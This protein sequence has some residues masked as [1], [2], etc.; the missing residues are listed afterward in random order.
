MATLL[1]NAGTA[2]VGDSFDFGNWMADLPRLPPGGYTRDWRTTENL[3]RE[4]ANEASRVATQLCRDDRAH[5][6][7]VGAKILALYEYTDPERDGW[8]YNK[9]IK[10]SKLPQFIH[11]EFAAVRQE[12]L[13]QRREEKG[14]KK[15]APLSIAGRRRFTRAS[16]TSH[17]N[18]PIPI[19]FINT[20]RAGI[21]IPLTWYSNYHLE[22][23]RDLTRL[24]TKAASILDS[25]GITKKVTILDIDR[26]LRNGWPT[27]NSSDDLTLSTYDICE[28]N[29]LRAWEQVIPAHDVTN[30][31]SNTTA[32]LVKHS[33]FF[34]NQI[35]DREATF[36]VWY[37][38][39]R[40]R[41]HQIFNDVAFER[42]EWVGEL[43]AALAAH[44]SDPF[45]LIISRTCLL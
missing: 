45:L 24:H 27:D 23:A 14:T 43:R 44:R 36:P 33:E 17:T 30:D 6:P 34:A 2:S 11:D 42:A 20:L 18:I 7:D 40:E 38:V 4:A 12:E 5:H 9:D 13:R 25:N 26:M 15:N 3:R 28:K 35:R 16:D 21:I 32:E 22:H 41:R 8:Y 10:W 39:E 37:D 29:H 1:P 31:E 19:I